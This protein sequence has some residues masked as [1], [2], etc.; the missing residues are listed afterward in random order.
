MRRISPALLLVLRDS[1]NRALR[2]PES[3]LRR[4]TGG[5]LLFNKLIQVETKFG[6]EFEV[7][8]RTMAQRSKP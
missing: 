4:H 5:N 7:D 3:I 6:F 8:I 2:G 1:S